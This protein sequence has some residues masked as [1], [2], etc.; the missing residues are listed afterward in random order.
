MCTGVR[1]TDKSGNL[2]FG[3]NL[4]VPMN[5]GE[6]IVIT[7]RNYPIPYRFIEAK[8][9]KRAIIG[10][11]IAVDKYPLYFDCVGESG[12]SIAGLDFLG[13]A[14]FTPK[15]IEGK[16]NLTP[17]E[18]MLWVVD[19]FDSVRDLK[20][21][22]KNVNLVND[23]F[24][25]SMP[26]ASL[27]WIVS[28]KEQSIVIEQ[29]ETKGLV[30]YDNPVGVLTNSPEFDWHLTNLTNYLNINPQD[31]PAKMWGTKDV[32]PFGVGTGGLGLPGEAMSPS[33]FVRIAYY[34]NHYPV[35]D[36]EVKNVAKF[37]NMLKAVAM[38]EGSVVDSSQKNVATAYTSCYSVANKTCYFNRLHDFTIQ[39]AQLDDS[40]V[41]ARELT[42]IS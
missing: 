35:E 23:P 27:H 24:N 1:F 30:A 5:Y 36:T 20:E 2:F 40:N 28:D 42:V 22:L 38:V 39:S 7:P 13:Y 4:D 16:I 11:G 26:V 19:E 3:R 15:P 14:H 25:S 37:F 10:V 9:T 32:E 6:K 34:N 33:R 31:A 12:L 17:Y 41:S 29:T 8:E 18:L 21:A